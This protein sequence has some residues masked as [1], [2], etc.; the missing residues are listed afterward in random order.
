M[1]FRL[2][3]FFSARPRLDGRASRS[4]DGLR[5]GVASL[6]RHSAPWKLVVSVVR[7]LSPLPPRSHSCG[8]RAAGALSR[9]VS[10]W[11]FLS[12]RL[13]G[14]WFVVGSHGGFLMSF[15]TIAKPKPAALRVS[16]S[17]GHLLSPC[18][19]V[20]ALGS[21]CASFPAESTLSTAVE[22]SVHFL[23]SFRGGAF[24]RFA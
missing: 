5:L 6:R 17:R 1:F 20:S 12:V 9:C 7:V 13:M 16:K 24:S 8:R 4:A 18:A 21:G 19:R 22:A 2:R 11:C 15:P 3:N 10:G 14:S 23:G